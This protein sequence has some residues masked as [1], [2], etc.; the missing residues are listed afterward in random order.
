MTKD[1][2]GDSCLHY[3]ANLHR[4]KILMY[5]IEE[6]QCPPGIE[7]RN[8]RNILHIAAETKQINMVQ[9]LVESEYC[10]LDPSLEDNT[11]HSAL[12]YACCSGD[13][14]IVRYLIESMSEY[15]K[16]EDM[17]NDMTSSA[18]SHSQTALFVKDFTTS[19]LSCACY[20]GNMSVVKYLVEECHCDPSRP[21]GVKQRVPIESA[22]IGNHF[23]VVKYL[24]NTPN[25]K[26]PNHEPGLIKLAV[27]TN[28]KMIEYLKTLSLKTQLPL[29]TT[30][31]IAEASKFRHSNI[32]S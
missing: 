13:L 23:D 3:A 28:A 10:K 4:F 19:P 15:M 2:Y 29:S 1:T 5:L 14:R 25:F 22:V 32:H 26:V 6:V 7:G 16:L 21:Q 27:P 20:H 9:Y 24:A 17:M 8:K 12:H 11:G 18:Q 31:R 30:D